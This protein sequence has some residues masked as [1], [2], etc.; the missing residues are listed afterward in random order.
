MPTR[1]NPS[2]NPTQ[3]IPASQPPPVEQAQ[4]AVN[5]QAQAP[6]GWNDPPMVNRSS[7]QQVFFFAKFILY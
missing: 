2:L 4:P 7:R 6:P 3:F 1:S 5:Y